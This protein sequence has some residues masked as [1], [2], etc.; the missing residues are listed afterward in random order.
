MRMGTTP[1]DAGTKLV[2]VLSLAKMTVTGRAKGAIAAAA[3]VQ[4][5]RDGLAKAR[6]EAA[7]ALVALQGDRGPALSPRPARGRTTRA[8]DG[9]GDCGRQFAR[10]RDVG[11]R[12]SSRARSEA[13]SDVGIASGAAVPITA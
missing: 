12:R 4:R 8:R 7:D 9:A 1:P 11:A 3:D 2:Y 5:R 13:W 6:A 10:P